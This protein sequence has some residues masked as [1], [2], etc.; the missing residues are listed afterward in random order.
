MQSVTKALTDIPFKLDTEALMRRAGVDAA[1]DYAEEFAALVKEAGRVARPKALYRESF[2]DERCAEGVTIDGVAFTSRTL[3][4]NLDKVHR[5][6]P[7]VATCGRELDR[8]PLE[9]GDCLAQFW[10][11]VIKAAVLGIARDYLSEHLTRR[12][13]LGKT[14]SM[15]PGS[16]DATVWPIEQQAL[17]FELFDSA[18]EQIGV[19]LTDTFLMIPSKTV[20]GVRF[21]TESDFRACQLCHREVC[22]SR[23]APFDAELWESMQHA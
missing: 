9:P 14:A 15:N 8:I 3:R 2:V 4:M 13:A 23:T 11:D 5:V 10:L 12:Y 7:Y 6:F 17:L 22:P 19:E 16:G 20:S 1:G 21:A 18:Q